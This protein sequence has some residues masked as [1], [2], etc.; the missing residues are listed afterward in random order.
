MLLKRKSLAMMT[1]MTALLLLVACGSAE[2]MTKYVDVSFSGMDS[3]GNA[4]YDVDETRLIEE[5]FNLEGHHDF[6]DAETARE[7]QNVLDAYTIEIEPQEGLSNGDQVKITVLVDENKTNK[8][9]GGEEEFTVEGLDEPELLTTED[10]EKNLVL[11]F[12]GVSGRGVSQIDN[13]FDESPLNN[14]TFEIEN[15]GKLKNGDEAVVIVGDEAEAILHSHGYMLDEDFQPTFT[16]KNLDEVAEQATDIKNLK[17]IERFLKEELNNVYKDTDYSFGSNTKYEIKQEQLMYRQFD[18]ESDTI[19]YEEG[20]HGNLIGIF[21]VEEYRINAEDKKLV[22]KFTAIYGF[23]DIILDEDGR[24]NL[25][26]LKTINERKDD[27]YSLE[28]VIQLSEGDGY[29]VVKK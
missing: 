24:A 25:S 19:H 6:P 26:E 5:I 22:Q 7:A 9:K 11:N 8:I 3:Q 20:N 13:I 18:K 16:V 10:V 17:D 27:T 28:S 1:V 4:S 14:L 21:S 12:N 15:D 29:E 2:D 23:S